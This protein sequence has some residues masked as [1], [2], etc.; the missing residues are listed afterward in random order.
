M[1]FAEQ[2]SERE[3]WYMFLALELISLATCLWIWLCTPNTIRYNPQFIAEENPS[4]AYFCVPLHNSITRALENRVL[5]I[6]NLVIFTFQTSSH[7][8]LQ[9]DNKTSDQ[10]AYTHFK[11][12]YHNFTDETE[13]TVLNRNGAD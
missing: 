12:L 13:V 8:L 2:M 10:L 5:A 9:Y 6:L 7:S 1:T 3:H 11:S 4:I